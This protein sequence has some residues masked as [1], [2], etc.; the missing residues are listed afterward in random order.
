MQG[1]IPIKA[2]GIMNL[3][4]AEEEEEEARVNEQV[5]WY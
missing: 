3:E 2:K 1:E 5:L 4:E